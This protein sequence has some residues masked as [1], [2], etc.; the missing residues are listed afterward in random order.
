MRCFSRTKVQRL[1]TPMSEPAVERRRD[2]TNGVL[3]KRESFFYVGRVESCASHEDIRVAVD[4]FRDTMYDDVC[5][6]IEWVLNV[7]A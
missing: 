5:A 2:G 7:W 1:E 3:E 4:V 6:M